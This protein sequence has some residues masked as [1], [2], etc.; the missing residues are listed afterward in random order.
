[1]RG[2]KGCSWL[3]SLMA[4]RACAI[5]VLLFLLCALPRAAG[6]AARCRVPIEV[7][8]VQEDIGFSSAAELDAAVETFAARR[9]AAFEHA[10]CD[11]A[12]TVSRILMHARTAAICEDM[13]P[14]EES[15]PWDEPEGAPAAATLD[16][17]WPVTLEDAVTLWLVACCSCFVAAAWFAAA[18]C[19]VAR[20]ACDASPTLRRAFWFSRDARR[21]LAATGGVMAVLDARGNLFL[22]VLHD[23]FHGAKG[24]C[25]GFQEHVH[26]SLHDLKWVDASTWLYGL[27]AVLG[28]RQLVA[29][30]AGARADPASEVLLYVLLKSST[31]ACAESH[32]IGSQWPYAT[33]VQLWLALTP[34]RPGV[35]A[36]AVGFV[37]QVFATHAFSG[38]AKLGRSRDKWWDSGTALPAA[39]SMPTYTTRR[40]AALARRLSPDVAAAAARAAVAFELLLAPLL[41]LRRRP[42]AAALLGF[43]ATNAATLAIFEFPLVAMGTAAALLYDPPVGRSRGDRRRP[44]GR[45][46]AL[47]AAALVAL[48][49][50]GLLASCPCAGRSAYAPWTRPTAALDRRFRQLG[51]FR[52]AWPL[53]ASVFKR[54][55]GRLY[56]EGMDGAHYSGHDWLAGVVISRSEINETRLAFYE[57]DF[58]ERPYNAHFFSWGASRSA[59]LQSVYHKSIDNAAFQRSACDALLLAP[60]NAS[61]VA[62]P[63]TDGR[64]IR[65]ALTVDLPAGHPAS[66]SGARR[67]IDAA[68][69][70]AAVSLLYCDT[71]LRP[72]VLRGLRARARPRAVSRVDFC[73]RDP[74]QNVAA[75]VAGPVSVAVVAEL[76]CETQELAVT[77]H[78]LLAPIFQ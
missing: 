6:A 31:H 64:G 67:T 44:G 71:V 36:G 41:A 51:Q 34:D 7:N 32:A 11:A 27:E 33:V 3:G 17:T 65:H 62:V 38:A 50:R 26:W 4:R 54:C 13:L 57:R 29:A 63:F 48:H 45:L 19:V 18:D 76:D 59:H 77:E 46:Q 72:H 8:G 66:I 16:A 20:G 30:A 2:R 5:P 47:A 78:D 1:M 55:T 39:F 58:R 61:S 9:A 12:C 49:A 73:K 24:L 40:A 53:F 43:H 75:F 42:V 23:V 14:G 74:V 70:A 37:F 52:Q 35:S 22:P 28:V 56:V 25:H 10:G 69:D 15:I 68:C 21:W 60:R